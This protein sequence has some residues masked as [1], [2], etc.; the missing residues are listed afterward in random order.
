MTQKSI[1]QSIRF[2]NYQIEKMSKLR[3]LNVNVHQF[4]RL[5]FDEHFR[6][7]YPKILEKLQKDDVPF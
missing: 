6:K 5:A 7:E 1:V 4:I 2:S 3:E